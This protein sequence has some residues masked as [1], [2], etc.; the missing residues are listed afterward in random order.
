MAGNTFR[1]YA[2]DSGY[3]LPEA[4]SIINPVP[5]SGGQ[6]DITSYLAPGDLDSDVI[7]AFR[8]AV[9]DLI[10]TGGYIWCPPNLRYPTATSVTIKSYHPI[11][12]VS[13][14]SQSDMDDSARAATGGCFF[15]V[16]DITDGI[17]IWD[18]PDDATHAF[19]GGGGGLI[20]CQFNDNQGGSADWRQYDVDSVV[21]AKN[22][23]YFES[24]E[25]FFGAIKGT[26]MRVGNCVHF[27]VKG[28]R[29][30]R[31]GDTDKSAVHVEGI[32]EQNSGFAGLYMYNTIMEGNH[33][34]PT[35]TVGEGTG[36]NL[37][38]CY[39]ENNTSEAE[40]QNSFILVEGT[41]DAFKCNFGALDAAT[42]Q[43]TVSPAA[44]AI[45]QKI[46]HCNFSG[47]GMA[48]DIT[49]NNAQY[50]QIV[51][52]VFRDGGSDTVDVINSESAATHVIDNVFYATGKVDLNS[53][54]NIVKGNTMFACLN[55]T[56]FDAPSRSVFE[57]NYADSGTSHLTKIRDSLIIPLHTLREV[58]GDRDVGNNAANGGVLSSETA[59]ILRW[60][61]S[62]EEVFWA[63]ANTD[64]VMVASIVLPEGFDD[65]SDVLVD[66]YVKTDNTGGGGIEAATFGVDSRWNDTGTQV[67]DNAVDATPAT[68]MHIVT[69][70]ISAADIPDSSATLNLFIS[71]GVHA[72]D[73]VILC[74]IRVRYMR[75]LTP[76]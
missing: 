23:Y 74:G 71:P 52:N 72:N 49:N 7:P 56:P 53:T 38:F 39:F 65:T 17:F 32:A 58:D 69:A 31:C 33:L 13:A 41:H 37:R 2:R 64:P 60:G 44:Q 9:D 63:A 50:I 12:I 28:G 76:L 25:N 24:Q 21:Y 75:A 20:R 66:L 46:A 51:G 8:R 10:D 4:G 36:A 26:A 11:F 3:L 59:P 55:D 35:M 16:A 67:L 47:D 6:V 42:T 40:L 18:D 29:I 45:F 22:A 30:S 57:D 62:G 19:Q 73:P 54:L 48:I 34:A 68:T 70:T 1:Q 5:I 61:S 43:V 15:P 27:Q 14:M